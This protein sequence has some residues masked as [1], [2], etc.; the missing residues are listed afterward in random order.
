MQSRFLFASLA[1][2]LLLAGCGSSTP[3]SSTAPS[4]SSHV[5]LQ[6]AF[7]V[8]THSLRTQGVSGQVTSAKVLI[9][10]EDTNKTVSSVT[11]SP[12]NSASTIALANDKTYRFETSALSGATELAWGKLSQKITANVTLDLPVNS[13]L[14]TASLIEGTQSQAGGTVPLYLNVNGPLGNA[15]PQGDYSVVYSAQNATV[16]SESK[17]GV[18]VKPTGSGDVT[19]RASVQGQDANHTTATLSASKVF[20]PVVQASTPWYGA[21]TGNW[22]TRYDFSMTVM[23]EFW[24]SGKTQRI[25]IGTVQNGAVSLNLPDMR[26]LTGALMIDGRNCTADETGGQFG[27]FA[28]SSFPLF[29]QANTSGRVG[30]S[31]IYLSGSDGYYYSSARL[32]YADRAVQGLYTYTCKE[33]YGYTSSITLNLD[34]AAGWNVLYSGPNGQWQATRLTDTLP[35]GLSWRLSDS[36]RLTDFSLQGNVDVTAPYLGS[37]VTYTIKVT[38]AGPDS[39]SWLYV[40]GILPSGVS[41]VSY[42]S[43]QGSFS[44]SDNAWYLGELTSG[45]SATLN[46]SVKVNS[47]NGTVS[48]SPYIDLAET[49]SSFDKNTLNNRTTITMDVQPQPGA[50]NAVGV[51]I[52]TTAPVLTMNDTGTATVGTEIKL[53]GTVRDAYSYSYDS[54]HSSGVRRVEVYEGPR[55]IG[56][57]LA[58]DLKAGS[59]PQQFVWSQAWTP[60]QRGPVRLTTLGYDN[61]GNVS[62]SELI[63]QVQ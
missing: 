11:L 30:G 15:V 14:Q 63:V 43:S 40:R 53:S 56:T 45:Q 7:P 52:D 55:L 20:Q 31:S 5:T 16:V 49:S 36:V 12:Q 50:S 58:A 38:N 21:V 19:V 9:F 51:K 18:V 39:G 6:M 2:G 13:I 34:L 54:T 32:L 44:G 35:G 29:G 8:D 27:A 22:P 48:S 37:T 41:T 4:T 10:D 57:V 59:D 62:R 46:V 26:G 33:S 17:L 25:P 47:G 23:G 60:G 61:A 3:D 24:L 42:A 1:W 28:V